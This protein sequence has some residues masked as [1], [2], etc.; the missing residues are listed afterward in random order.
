MN[1]RSC[2]AILYPSIERY[3]AIFVFFEIAT[4]SEHIFY[5]TNYIGNVFLQEAIVK[6]LFSIPDIF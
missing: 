3:Q 1:S 5:P 6:I 2:E 4:F